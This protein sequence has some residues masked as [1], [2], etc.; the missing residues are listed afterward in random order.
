MADRYKARAP[1]A[2]VLSLSAAISLGINV[3]KDPNVGMT[4]SGVVLVSD[5]PFDEAEAARFAAL[6]DMGDDD[7]IWL[8]PFTY[9][10]FTLDDGEQPG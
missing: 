3:G 7:T 2:T 8:P 10:R 4:S 1:E 9:A 5:K 6:V